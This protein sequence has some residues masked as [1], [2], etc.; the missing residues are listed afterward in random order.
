ME[1]PCKDCAHGTIRRK[2]DDEGLELY[3]Q[4]CN[5][6]KK[7]WLVSYGS[8]HAQQLTKLGR[9]WKSKALRQR[10]A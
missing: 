10:G 2:Y 4:T 5:T 9:C 6:C 3:V 7:S 1:G 8:Y